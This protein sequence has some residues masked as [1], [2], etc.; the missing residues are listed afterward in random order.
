VTLGLNRA[1]RRRTFPFETSNGSTVGGAYNVK[2]LLAK[3]IF[4]FIELDGSRH[5]FNLSFG[6]YSNR[7]S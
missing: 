3:T 6:E 4:E 2:R 1:K 5:R 7:F